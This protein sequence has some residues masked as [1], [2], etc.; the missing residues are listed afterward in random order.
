MRKL[1]LYISSSLDG[2]IAGPNDD[3]SFLS[4]VQTED[5]DYGYHEFTNTTDTVIMGNRTY[6]WILSQNVEF[7]HQDK[8]SYIVTRKTRQ[9]IG[10]L[11]FY[12]GDLSKLVRTLKKEEGK[13]IFCDGGSFVVNELLKAKL[14]DELIISV[15]PAILGKGTKLFKDEIPGQNLELLSSKRFDSG[16]VQLHYRIMY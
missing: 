6:N 9:S 3:L 12:T 11:H 14:F 13:S 16:L 15:I 4:R 5:E 1:V 2:Y 10:N 8:T 7:P